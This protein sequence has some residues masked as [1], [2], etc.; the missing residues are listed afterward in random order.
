[1]LRQTLCLKKDVVANT[2]K[3]YTQHNLCQ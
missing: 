2:S 1:L 3:F